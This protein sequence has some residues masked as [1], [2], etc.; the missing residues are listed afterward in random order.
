MEHL[1]FYLKSDVV[2]DICVAWRKA[3]QT[4]YKVH[5]VT[6]C[7]IITALSGQVPLLSNLKARFGKFF[8]KC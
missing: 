6:H 5:P 3:L 8:K 1:C 7:D 4:V 2:E